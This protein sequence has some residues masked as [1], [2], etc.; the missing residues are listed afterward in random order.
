MT[1]LK[2]KVNGKVLVPP[3]FDHD[4]FTGPLHERQCRD[5][6]FFILFTAF[7]FGAIAYL[8][9][10]G[11]RADPARLWHGHDKY[12]NV[13]GRNNNPLLDLT[14]SG[15]DFSE[16]PFCEVYQ[17]SDLVNGAK[18]N[19][20]PCK[21]CIKKCSK[22]STPIA[23][24]CTNLNL[25]NA[26][27]RTDI[28]TEAIFGT[29]LS[30]FFKDAGRDLDIAGPSLAILAVI[31]VALGLVFILLLRFL[32][33]VVVWITVVA[34]VV[35]SIGG[36]AYLWVQWYLH[37]QKL[38]E[39]REQGAEFL[40]GLEIFVRNLMI[41]AIV[42]TIFT[43]LLLVLLIAMRNRI[44]LVIALFKEAGKAVGAMPLLMFQPLWTCL[45]LCVV[46]ILWAIGFVLIL[47]SGE[48]QK[49]DDG[50]VFVVMPFIEHMRWYHVFAFLWV[51]QFI[52][53]CQDVTI[54]GA[55]AEWYFTRNKK[56][57]G[58]PILTSV[59]RLFRYHMGSVAFGSLLIA[60][61]KFIR[62]IFKYLE[63]RLN[64]TTNQ[65]CSF[66]LKCCQCCLWCF[67]KFLKFLSRNAYIEI[68]IYGYSFCKAAQKAFSLLV[69]NALR[70]AAINSVGAFV[71]V[72]TKL[73]IVAITITIGYFILRTKQ[74]LTYI[75]VPLLIV[76]IYSY[77]IA[78]CFISVYEMCID[79]LFLCFCEDCERNDGINHPYYMSRGLM[80]FVENSK[81]ALEALEAR[82]K[83]GKLA[84]AVR[85]PSA[86]RPA[87]ATRPSTAM[88][89]MMVSTAP[90]VPPPAYY[91]TPAA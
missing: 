73:A 37:D 57:L 30:D 84:Q 6:L 72:L 21:D 4:Q 90:G 33:Q 70:V 9:F 38:K 16:R 59:K 29:S 31:A 15:K 44:R 19:E 49:K 24:Y 78:H 62:I 48:P 42:A 7:V 41:G 27:E 87:P 28:A 2:G 43:L 20:A 8:V 3:G 66:C 51:S 10:V 52:L 35:G 71:L 75:W 88:S 40:G 60:I 13:C 55:V 53:A 18:T 46:G 5:V 85:K 77:F 86:V 74:E 65:F 47:T 54:A 36:T 64:G 68:A 25:T 69:N 91:I 11:L 81:K 61:V 79:T 1:R 22:P 45:W 14:N 76:F 83:E 34:M 63:K 89:T 56:L 82:Q 12:G 32:A 58:W 50:V 23:F 67:E 80:Q 39:Q 17:V 26:G